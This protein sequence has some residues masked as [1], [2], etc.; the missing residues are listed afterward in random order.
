LNIT[1]FQSKANNSAGVIA[2]LDNG[3]PG[4]LI[5]DGL[6]IYNSHDG[7]RPRRNT[8]SFWT[9]RNSWITYNR[10]DCIENDHFA[11]GLVDDSLFDGC[12]WF[13][14]SRNTGDNPNSNVVT[15]QNSLIRIQQMPGPFGQ[16]DPSILGSGG[17]YKMESDSPSWRLINNIFYIEG[18]ASTRY[19]PQNEVHS[20]DALGFGG[21]KLVECS[22]NII[23]WGGVGE[24][25]GNVPNDPSCVTVIT[26]VS[27]WDDAKAKWKADHPLVQR[28]VGVDEIEPEPTPEPPAPPPPP[29]PTPEPTDTERPVIT[30]MIPEDGAV[31]SHGTHFILSLEASDNVGVTRLILLVNG[32]VI[33]TGSNVD[34]ITGEYTFGKKPGSVFTIEGIADDAEGNQARKIVLVS[35][36]LRK[37]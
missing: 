26:D 7:I 17:L 6:R 12:Y 8:D 22:G 36:P 11:S 14:S 21:N 1:W 27:V 32:E 35:T 25:P 37:K 20:I 9:I 23:I 30:S 34:A 16:T 29:P 13:L 33:S 3:G 28:L 5:F 2:W 19:D 31:I 10:D 4:E 24:F 18:L 15:V